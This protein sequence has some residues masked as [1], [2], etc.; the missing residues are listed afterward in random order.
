[1]SKPISKAEAHAH[2]QRAGRVTTPDVP[3]APAPAVVAAHKQ[4]QE[5]YLALAQAKAQSGDAIE[6]EKLYQHAEHYFRLMSGE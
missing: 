3:I 6:A 4:K 1:M 5:K 2:L